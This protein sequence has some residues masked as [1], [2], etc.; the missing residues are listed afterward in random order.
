MPRYGAPGRR[1][2]RAA[3][4]QTA[5]VPVQQERRTP[6]G[7]RRAVPR[8]GAAHAGRRADRGRAGRGRAVADTV[9]LLASELCENSVLHAGTEFEVDLR[10]DGRRGRR[11]GQ[12]PRR[13]PTG[14]APVPAAPP[15]RPGRRARPR[16]AAADPPRH[17]VGH[18]ARAGRHAPHLV[19]G[20]DRRTRRRARAA[21]P[22]RLAEPAPR[23]A[24]WAPVGA[25]APAAAPA[26][27]RWPAGSTPDELVAELVRQAAGGARRRGRGRRGRRGRRRRG[28]HRRLAGPAA[29]GRAL[30]GRRDDRRA[31]HH[32]TAARAGSL[33]RPTTARRRRRTPRTS[34]SWSPTGSRWR[35]SRRGCARWTSAAAPGWPTSPTPASCSGSRSTSS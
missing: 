21:G 3:T 32:R 24:R 5:R 7:A 2:T 34:P 6:A 1:R 18:A 26:A 15:L 33:V 4:V 20:R 10:I 30:G 35:W 12:R 11:D 14:A 22:G 9:V 23:R 28:A 25:R 13:G 8:Q 29:G 19:L 16:A 17:G 31:A 27:R